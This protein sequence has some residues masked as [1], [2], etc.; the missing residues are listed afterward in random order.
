MKK[1]SKADLMLVIVAL[2]WGISYYLMDVCLEEMGPLTL[3][4]YRFLGAFI[5]IG[6]FFFKRLNKVD[7]LAL[8]YSAALGL[9][10][11]VV[12]I[13]ATFGVKYTTLSNAGF[14]CALSVI[15]TPVLE[16]FILRNR[17]EKRVVIAVTMSVIGIML[18]TL[19][20][21][22]TLDMTNL[23]GDLLCLMCAFSCAVMLIITDKALNHH[24]VDAFQLGVYQLGF[25]GVY[26]TVLAFVFETPKLPES[27]SVVVGLLFLSL[28]CTGAAYVIQ[29]LAQQYTTATRVGL[30]LTLEPVFAS[31]AAFFLAGEV[32]SFKGY[33]GAIVMLAA[34][35]IMEIDFSKFSKKLNK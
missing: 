2:G 30:I 29:T 11:V 18:L 3:N 10:L 33:L 1:Q 21:D 25:T 6:I 7:M 16:L 12:Y 4:A 23:R 20:S 19:K 5:V 26:M 35:F 31:V 13:G 8:K 27:S 24:K 17:P 15:F 14:L 22:F 32:L 28:F 9:I 34:L